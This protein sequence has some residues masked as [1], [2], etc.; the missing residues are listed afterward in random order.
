VI[1][2]SKDKGL[3]N[4]YVFYSTFTNVFIFVT[5]LTFFLFFF[6]NVFFTSMGITAQPRDEHLNIT[7]PA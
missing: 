4:I 7:Y 2:M 5:F 6:W 3:K 1:I